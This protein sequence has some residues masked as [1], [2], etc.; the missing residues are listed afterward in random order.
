MNVD[1]FIDEVTKRLEKSSP[2]PWRIVR[3]EKDDW[4][5]AGIEC[6][7]YFDSNGNDTNDVCHGIEHQGNSELIASAPTDLAKA[8]G[9]IE[10]QRIALENVLGDAKGQNTCVS[11]ALNHA[12]DWVCENVQDITAALETADRIAQGEK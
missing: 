7:E 9:I 5:T 11:K 2:R 4:Y 10:A 6:P 12:C 8:I 3:Y 1:K